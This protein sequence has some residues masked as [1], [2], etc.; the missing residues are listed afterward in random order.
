[1]YLKISSVK[2]RPFCLSSKVLKRFMWVHPVSWLKTSLLDVFI[3]FPKLVAYL[4]TCNRFDEFEVPLSD[5]RYHKTTSACLSFRGLHHSDCMWITSGLSYYEYAKPKSTLVE[6]SSS[7]STLVFLFVY[8][9]SCC[10]IVPCYSG[11]I[12]YCRFCVYSR[13]MLDWHIHSDSRRNI[14][15]SVERSTHWLAEWYMQLRA[16]A[17]LSSLHLQTI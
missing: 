10:Y 12:R 8:V 2:W 16:H 1:M 11:T 4:K 17:H 6:K 9:I 13:W 14:R 5:Y 3:G 7:S 15:D